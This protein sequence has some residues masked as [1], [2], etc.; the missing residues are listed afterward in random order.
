ML[1]DGI[2][3]GGGLVSFNASGSRSWAAGK[4]GNG[5]SASN[6]TLDLAGTFSPLAIIWAFAAASISWM[7]MLLGVGFLGGALCI[8]TA[9]RGIEL[10][11][12][13]E[14]LERVGEIS[15][16]TDGGGTP[17][18]LAPNLDLEAV[19]GESLES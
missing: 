8:G 5:M 11:V 17:L 4:G 12:N 6:L 3:G 13:V 15:V 7:F 10:L 19:A 18:A 9:I 14:A 16:I 2:G 1:S